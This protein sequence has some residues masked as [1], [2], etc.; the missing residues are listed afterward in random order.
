MHIIAMGCPRGGVRVV[1]QN[2]EEEKIFRRKSSNREEEKNPERTLRLR[3]PKSVKNITEI[4]K[5]FQNF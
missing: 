3:R 4:R 1:H 5:Y 2:L